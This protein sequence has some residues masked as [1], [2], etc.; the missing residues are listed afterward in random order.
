VHV[1]SAFQRGGSWAFVVKKSSVQDGM[2]V[3]FNSTENQSVTDVGGLRPTP[4]NRK[5]PIRVTINEIEI[6]FRFGYVTDS[7]G[8]GWAECGTTTT[9]GATISIYFIP[10]IHRYSF[11]TS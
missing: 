2:W 4:I 3:R 9:S 11:S 7:K 5:V 10:F 1:F 8:T 6:S